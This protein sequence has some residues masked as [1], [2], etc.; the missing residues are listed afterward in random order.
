MKWMASG[1]VRMFNVNYS[2]QQ[3]VNTTSWTPAQLQQQIYLGNIVPDAR[4]GAPTFITAEGGEFSSTYPDYHIFPRGAR[5]VFTAPESG[6]V[7]FYSTVYVMGGTNTSRTRMRLEVRTGAKLGEGTWVGS[8]HR[9]FWLGKD[10]YSETIAHGM[11]LT[12]GAT[13]NVCQGYTTTAGGGTISDPRITVV[14][15][16]L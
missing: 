11:Q 5:G 3:V 12:P 6:K 14:P 10:A 9:V 1:S 4:V 8:T 2:P 7:M 16:P 13:Y 15:F